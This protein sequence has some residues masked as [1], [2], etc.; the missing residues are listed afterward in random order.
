MIHKLQLD[1][2]WYYVAIF[3]NDGYGVLTQEK[4]NKYNECEDV[5]ETETLC[6]LWDEDGKILYDDNIHVT[7]IDFL[8]T[9]KQTQQ[10]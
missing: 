7:A 9:I 5:Y 4:V 6:Y 8:N 3:D 2:G 1:N 10:L